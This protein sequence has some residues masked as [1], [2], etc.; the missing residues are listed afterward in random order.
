MFKLFNFFHILVLMSVYTR[1]ET[2]FA[3]LDMMDLYHG[4]HKLY[5]RVLVTLTS[6]P[7]LSINKSVT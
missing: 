4:S 7:F 6:K 1:E 3:L 2:H 5:S